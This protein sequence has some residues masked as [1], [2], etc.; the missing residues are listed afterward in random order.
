LAEKLQKTQK[1]NPI[2]P[3]WLKQAME[4]D[5]LKTLSNLHMSVLVLSGNADWLVPPSETKLLQKTLKEANYPDYK[6][7]IFPGLDHRF[8][9]VKS[10]KESFRLMTSI[11]YL[12]KRY[13]VDLLVLETILTWLKNK[14]SVSSFNAE[15][16]ALNNG[17]RESYL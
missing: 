17:L 7:K 15:N 10:M 14:S 5:Q 8:T 4:Y 9:K 3:I 6:V 12:F 13:P 16:P 1:V 11:K 2:P